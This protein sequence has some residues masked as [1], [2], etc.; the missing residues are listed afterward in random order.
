MTYLGLDI[1]SSAVKAAV[2]TDGKIQKLVMEPLPENL[3]R[4]GRI[5]S[6]EA[7]SDVLREIVRKHHISAR[8]CAL[9]LPSETAMTRRIAMPYMTVDQLAVNLP[10]EFHD[11]IQGDKDLYFY[12]YAVVGTEE[13]EDGQPKTLELL[14]SAVTKEEIAACRQML[15]KAGLKL[16]TAVPECMAYRNLLRRYE[17]DHPGEHPAEYCVIDLGHEAI[18]MH[19]FRGSVYEATRLVDIGGRDLDGA[20]ADHMDVDPHV[21]ASY[22]M[23]N[24]EDAQLLPECMELYN[25]AAVEVLRAIHC[26]GF[27]TPDSDLR[28]VYLCGGGAQMEP[29]TRTLRS[30]LELTVH[31][32]CELMPEGGELLYPAAV[33]AALQ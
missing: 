15:G 33:G 29:L 13:D 31:D 3:V 27:N 18:R 14:A 32:I 22:R 19:V 1:G 8:R 25:R 12:D 6:P 9:A 10:Y 21:A 2:V 23:N 4:D 7:M 30:Q 28:D 5:L 16:T 24:Y 17:Q 11:Y 26:Y 20:I